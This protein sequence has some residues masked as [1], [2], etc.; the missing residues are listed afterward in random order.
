MMTIRATYS[1]DRFSTDDWTWNRWTYSDGTTVLANPT[2]E[3]HF[4]GLTV[5]YRFR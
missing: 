4:V 5:N 2:Q 1:Y 3:V